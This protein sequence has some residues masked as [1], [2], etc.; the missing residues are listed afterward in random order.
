M[1]SLFHDIC[2]LVG[3]IVVGV[4]ILRVAAGAVMALVDWIDDVLEVH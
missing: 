3:Y 4:F 2:L 1:T